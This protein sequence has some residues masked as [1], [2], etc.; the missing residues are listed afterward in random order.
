[1]RRAG[2]SLRRHADPDL[3]RERPA[4]PAQRA[5]DPR[6]AHLRARS[7]HVSALRRRHRAVRAGKQGSRRG[8]TDTAEPTAAS[9][10]PPLVARAVRR[11]PIVVGLR[12]P[13]LLVAAL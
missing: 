9:K 2:R 3:A 1:M 13:G 6:P 12:M 10:G 8:V 5:V 4:L 11:P 7:W